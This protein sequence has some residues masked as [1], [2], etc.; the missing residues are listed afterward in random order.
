MDLLLSW[1]VKVNVPNKEGW[2]PLADAVLRCVGWPSVAGTKDTTVVDILLKH[3][4][5]PNI[6]CPNGVS[7]L[8]LARRAGQEELVS[9]L[10]E[11]GTKD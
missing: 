4:A 7:V 3:G 6:H 1:G 9:L 5:D 11:H 2:T 8:A 10:L